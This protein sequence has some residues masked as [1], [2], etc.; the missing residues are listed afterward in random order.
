MN[1]GD[2]LDIPE[3]GDEFFKNAKVRPGFVRKYSVL[4][5]QDVYEWLQEQP[6]GLER[7][8]QLLREQMRAE[9][10]RNSGAE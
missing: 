6:T 8:N 2:E 10:E 7:A 5:D 3:L 4:L 9:R 1:A